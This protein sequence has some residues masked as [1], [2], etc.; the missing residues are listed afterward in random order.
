MAKPNSIADD[1]V[2][3]TLMTD[4]NRA[5]FQS[6]GRCD[7]SIA[8]IFCEFAVLTAL[9]ESDEAATD[10]EP[11]LGLQAAADRALLALAAIPAADQQDLKTKII[12]YETGGPRNQARGLMAAMLEAAIG[13]DIDR[14]KPRTH[15]KRQPARR[16]ARV[17][18]AG[19][20]HRRR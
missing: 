1:I 9:L 8:E 4:Q 5:R 14:L 18:A 7:Q 11:R 2:E 10:V 12:A 16:G 3:L 19:K 6:M 13:A 20:P 17:D 15:L